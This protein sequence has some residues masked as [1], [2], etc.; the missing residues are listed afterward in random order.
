MWQL[1]T[2]FNI[3]VLYKWWC[4]G[5]QWTFF[6]LPAILVSRTNHP[7]QWL[8]ASFLF[9]Y[10]AFFMMFLV[11]LYISCSLE[12]SWKLILWLTGVLVDFLFKRT[13][14]FHLHRQLVTIVLSVASSLLW[15]FSF[16]L[17][18]NDALQ[19]NIMWH[20]H[21]IKCLFMIH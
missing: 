19:V 5:L 4:I 18:I 16:G 20:V 2:A 14:P 15:M 11:I 21:F 10:N 8:N 17:S 3:I 9:C 6:L 7:L 13:Y 1:L 12:W